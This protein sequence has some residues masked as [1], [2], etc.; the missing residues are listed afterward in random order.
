MNGIETA[1]NAELSCRAGYD[2]PDG[3]LDSLS[4][5]E[6]LGVFILDASV[7]LGAYLY[8]NV[9]TI[10]RPPQGRVQGVRALEWYGS[11]PDHNSPELLQAYDRS[12]RGYVY[13]NTAKE[14]EEKSHP[15][16]EGVI[17]L[18]KVKTGS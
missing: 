7:G 15:E 1:G 11:L 5:G 3:L 8:V 10:R 14:A 13:L 2:H 12:I 18:T 9:E 4:T 17:I 16:Y 6:H